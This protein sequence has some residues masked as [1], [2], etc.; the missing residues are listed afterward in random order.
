LLGILTLRRDLRSV[1]FAAAEPWSS[2]VMA[3]ST[4]PL[5]TVPVLVVQTREDPSLAQAVKQKFARQLCANR[6]RMLCIDLPGKDHATT[7]SQSAP[8]TLDWIAGRF[9]G[10]RAPSDCGHICRRYQSSSIAWL[11]SSS[12]VNERY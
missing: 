7:A 6:V 1:D 10:I 2:F 3:N 12:E 9:A 8:Q 4:T 5:Q 11:A